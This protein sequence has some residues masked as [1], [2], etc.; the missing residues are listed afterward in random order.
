MCLNCV[1][2]YKYAK[3]ASHDCS[4][5]IDASLTCYIYYRNIYEVDSLCL[6][7]S[8]H[9]AVFRTGTV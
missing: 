3:R 6:S 1:H 9:A 7:E 4:H 2:C 5:Y 8:M